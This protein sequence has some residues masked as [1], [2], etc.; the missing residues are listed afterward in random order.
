MA[1]RNC[2]SGTN[3]IEV[4]LLPFQCCWCEAGG[5]LAAS[6]RA[7][8]VQLPRDPHHGNDEACSRD[9]R[10]D[11]THANE[12][13]LTLAA[14]DLGRWSVA[15][16]PGQLKFCACGCNSGQSEVVQLCTVSDE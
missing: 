3:S 7:P 10:K 14:P 12:A 2:E 8:T 5:V 1:N 16:Q 11:S 15:M 9:D 6:L 13:I 4:R